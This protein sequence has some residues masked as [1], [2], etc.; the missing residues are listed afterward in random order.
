MNRL[1]S[2]IG[3][4]PTELSFE[5]FCSKLTTERQ[6]IRQS[7]DEFRQRKNLAPKR[8]GKA[9]RVALPPFATVAKELNLTP[10]EVLKALALLK[11]TK[12]TK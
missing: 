5:A 7:L 12:E 11:T 2:V 1:T 9:T 10:A 4:S 8:S 3:P 6:R